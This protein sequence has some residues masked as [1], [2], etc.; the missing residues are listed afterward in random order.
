VSRFLENE[1]I[2]EIKAVENNPSRR[3]RFLVNVWRNATKNLSE[4]CD[5]R[6][7]LI[8]K[9][10]YLW[11]WFR[12]DMILIFLNEK[13]KHKRFYRSELIN[14]AIRMFNN[15]FED[16]LIRTK[17]RIPDMETLVDA[18]TLNKDIRYYMDEKTWRDAEQTIIKLLNAEPPPRKDPEFKEMIEHKLFWKGIFYDLLEAG[19]ELGNKK[20]KVPKRHRA[21]ITI[22]KRYL[23]WLEYNLEEDDGK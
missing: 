22:L 16:L 21:R 4:S 12:L 2:N 18:V 7:Y 19:D 10:R 14:Y 15:W 23:I 3:N 6:Y 17:S 8:A 9:G 20:K 13:K 1:I 5:R 11:D